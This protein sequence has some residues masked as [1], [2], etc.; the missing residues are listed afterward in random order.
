MANEFVMGA[1]LNL[2]VNQYVNQVRSASR[3]TRE[4]RGDT[5]QADR[6]ARQWRD[7]QGRLN[8]TLGGYRRAADL[9]GRETREFS[10]EARGLKGSLG[11]L[12]SLVGAVFTGV[13][14]SKGFDWLVGANA[15]METYE[16]TLTVVMKSHE[17]AM[18]TLA[19]AEKFSAS[20]PFEI[21]QVVEATTRLTSYGLE[22]QKVLGITGDMAAVMGKD[23]MQAVE[24]VA[25]AQT[26][27]VERL[28]EFGITKDMI[29]EAAD[30]LGLDVINNKGQITD[31][32]AFNVAL[33]SLMEE[34]FQGGMEMQAK[35]WKGMV[36][37]AKDFMGR[38]GKQLGAPLFEAAKLR[39]ADFLAFTNQLEENRTI[40]E[41]IG[42]V[43][44][45]VT[46]A[47]TYISNTVNYV[48]DNWGTIEPAVAGVTA[49]FIAFK[50][51]SRVA[52]AGA[53][54]M[55]LKTTI[56]ATV[57]E[58]GS[59]KV[60][61][62]NAVMAVNPV[63]LVVAAI[64]ALVGILVLAAM[65]SD[66][67]RAILVGVWNSIV[68][69][70]TPAV[71]TVKAAIMT[72]FIAVMTWVET[73]WPKIQA[74]V[75]FVWSFLGPYIQTWLEFI[76]T[77]IQND[78]DIV[79]TIVKGAWD[80]VTA[81]IKTA[82]TVISNIIG[83]WLNIFTGDFE[84]A[85]QNVLNIFS[86]LGEGIK[87]FFSAFGSTIWDSG[88]KIMETLA[89]GIKSAVMAPVNAIKGGFK[90]VRD[91]LPFSDAKKGPFSD[92]TFN[93]G[94]IMTTLAEG[95]KSQAGSLQRAVTSAFGDTGVSVDAA[96]VNPAGSTKAAGGS[97]TT[98]AKLFDKLE[99]HGAEGMDEETLADKVI[100]KFYEK[101]TEADDVLGSE[102]KGVLLNA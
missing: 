13:A 79:L 91:L 21:P 100:A 50:A 83:F 14:V 44:S 32:K 74:I 19:W 30:S 26:G 6:S 34:R 71:N 5:D 98:I 20:T 95:V 37:N 3:M 27:E 60:A 24:A 65:K 86:G 56:M 69:V 59:I 9:A 78:F 23:L 49:A 75:S 29:K 76:K 92:L 96:S 99:I 73:Y 66:K 57:A 22:A 31:M 63:V 89:E 35:T 64:A 90:K 70:V 18:E 25:D 17:K 62:L 52:A 87:D 46:T 33:F 58:A 47:G 38:L 28:K 42:R 15:E 12:R 43:H 84:A 72:A 41:W 97:V 2:G 82:W 4:F 80:M 10:N 94:R 93:G 45:A 51:A 61:L 39:L 48:N 67:F 102:G 1:R 77:A 55:A 11:G 36:S 53:K 81:V 101:L 8:T 88:V 54:A 16:N 68:S 85:G 40:E 7:S